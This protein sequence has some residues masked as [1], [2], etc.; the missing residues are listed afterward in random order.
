MGCLASSRRHG[1]TAAASEGFSALT[2]GAACHH[3]WVYEHAQHSGGRQN[4]SRHGRLAGPR[5]ACTERGHRRAVPWA[6]G[7][8]TARGEVARGGAL[9]TQTQPP[10][11][12]P[13]SSKLLT[14]TSPD[15]ESYQW[16]LLHESCELCGWS[17]PQAHLGVLTCRE[18]LAAPEPWELVAWTVKMYDRPLRKDPAANTKRRCSGVAA[19]EPRGNRVARV[20]AGPG[21]HER[22]ARSAGASFPQPC[23]SLRSC[24]HEWQGVSGCSTH[25][26]P[27][28]GL[29]QAL[30]E[31]RL[32]AGANES[33]PDDVADNRCGGGGVVGRSRWEESAYF[34]GP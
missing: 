31:Q 26:A 14:Q 10:G 7:G 18:V 28:R 23:R 32:A 30:L 1:D 9:G 17:E 22:T 25:A 20:G 19:G 27:R 2:S 34:L 21:Q 16:L 6:L 11:H 5:A 4:G 24:P 29:A 33:A 15:A 13:S 3:R 8:E 12:Q